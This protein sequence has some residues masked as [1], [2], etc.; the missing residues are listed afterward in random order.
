MTEQMLRTFERK[1][2]RRIYGP[3]QDN[4]RWRTR[5]DSE[6]YNLYKGMIIVDDIKIRSIGRAGHIIRMEGRRPRKRFLMGNF[7]IQD[8]L[9]NQEQDGRT[10]S[11]GKRHRS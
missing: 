10:S 9:E 4:G 11:G 6:I 2:L 1:I 8:Q 7:I 5:W 3:V